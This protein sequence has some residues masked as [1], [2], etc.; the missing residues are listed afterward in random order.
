MGIAFNHTPSPKVPLWASIDKYR[1]IAMIYLDI[2]I[3]FCLY[4]N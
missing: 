2:I 1:N 4:S 3:K